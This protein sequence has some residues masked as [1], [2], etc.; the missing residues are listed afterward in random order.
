MKSSTKSDRPFHH[1]GP[2]SESFFSAGATGLLSCRID[3]ILPDQYVVGSIEGLGFPLYLSD[4]SNP[5]YVNQP[6]GII[7]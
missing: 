6:V 3:P 5:V 4:T 7:S 2:G 1:H